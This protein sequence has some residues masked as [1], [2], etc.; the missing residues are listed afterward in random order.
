MRDAIGSDHVRIEHRGNSLFVTATGVLG[1]V[2][3]MVL[4]RRVR[5]A[6]RHAAL[7]VVMCDFRGALITLDPPEYLALLRAELADP[8]PVPVGFVGGEWLVCLGVAHRVLMGR[9]GLERAF[10][11]TVNEA[12]LWCGGYSA[13]ASRARPRSEPVATTAQAKPRR[14][15]PANNNRPHGRSLPALRLV[16]PA[17]AGPAH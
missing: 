15:R 16:W 2:E 3:C 4:L 10:F 17:R 6:Q 12:A 7:A 11:A 14:P 13:Q 9:R 1:I 8:I 5:I